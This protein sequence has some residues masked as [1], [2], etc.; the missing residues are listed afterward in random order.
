[1]IDRNPLLPFCVAFEN[2]HHAQIERQNPRVGKGKGV[3]CAQ[4]CRRAGI[5]KRVWM[6][7]NGLNPVLGITGL[8]PVLFSVSIVQQPKIY[9]CAFLGINHGNPSSEFPGFACLNLY[10]WEDQIFSIPQEIA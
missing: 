7:K 8:F 2:W 4:S 10:F 5:I 6:R 1:M 9:V 3:F